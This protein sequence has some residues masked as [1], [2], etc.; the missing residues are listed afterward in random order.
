MGHRRQAIQP[1]VISVTDEAVSTAQTYVLRTDVVRWA[2]DALTTQ[3]IHPFFL[4]YL[5]LHS[6]TP[7]EDSPTPVA[8]SWKSFGRRYLSMPGGP[9]NKPYYRPFFNEVSKPGRYW[10]NQNLAGS[11]A[12]GSL[13]DVPLTVV[14]ISSEGTFTLKRESGKLALENL[15]YGD[16]IPVLALSVF[17]LRNFGFK[18]DSGTPVEHDVEGLFLLDFNFRHASDGN[19]VGDAASIF[20]TRHPTLPVSDIFEAHKN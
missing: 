5:H 10:M 1:K 7:D 19:P 3:R 17:M 14:D 6:L 11:W 18:S 2:I 9:V 16:P 13:R 12:P 8:P 20:T 4:A 15:L